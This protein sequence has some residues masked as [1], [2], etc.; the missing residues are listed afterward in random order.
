MGELLSD[1]PQEADGKCHGFY[2]TGPRK[3]QP[4]TNFPIKGG[5]VCKTHGGNLPKVKT[6]AAARNIRDKAVRK[7]KPSQAKLDL[8]DEL[9][10]NLRSAIEFKDAL[11]EL[12]DVSNI[13]Y[14][15]KTGE[16]IR[17]E[18]QEWTRSVD[19]VHRIIVDI[20]K[21]GIEE[22]R[23]AIQKEQAALVAMVIRSMLDR[24]GLSPEQALLAPVI[25]KEEMLAISA[26]VSQKP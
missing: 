23:I 18:V 17:G 4:C 1:K 9:E 22:K 8:L 24:L 11:E 15:G 26:E 10:R 21:L 12:V 5:V 16:Q 14:E 3:G 7:L 19:R 2:R 6:A 20:Y 13:R 25:I